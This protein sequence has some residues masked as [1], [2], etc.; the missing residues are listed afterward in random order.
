VNSDDRRRSRPVSNNSRRS[1]GR[2]TGR[3]ASGRN[4]A[5]GSGRAGAGR[6]GVQGSAT[7]GSGRASARRGG[8]ERAGAPSSGRAG[9]GRQSSQ[10][11]TTGRQAGRQTGRPNA[12]RSGSGRQDASSSA[13]R[14]GRESQAAPSKSKKKVRQSS[15]AGGGRNRTI[16]IAVVVVLV[17]ALIGVAGYMLFSSATR[18]LEERQAILDSVQERE[19]AAPIAECSP[20]NLD[21]KIGDHSTT[22]SVGSGWNTQITVT[23][24]GSEPCLTDGSASSVGLVV[25]S[26]TYQL[27]DTTACGD[28]EDTKPLLI[29]SGR[30]WN[31]TVSWDG[32]DYQDCN[33]GDVAAAG[34]Y[35][36]KIKFLDEDKGEITV[37][38]QDV[39]TE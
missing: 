37:Q 14:S 24:K 7:S 2:A 16:P 4:G 38:L 1:G 10:R 26:G 20:E 22:A 32:N 6:S 19:V 8:S 28:P 25:T 29:G 39:A 34:T 35:V 3:S 21:F 31:T 11:S 17:I 33:P 13:G 5:S 18:S 27:V 15:S 9:T 30:S 23:N 12:G 36:M